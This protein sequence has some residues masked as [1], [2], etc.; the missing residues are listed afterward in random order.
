MKKL[1]ASFLIIVLAVAL[2]SVTAFA[3]K[4][5][6]NYATNLAWKSA[7]SAQTVFE[8]GVATSTNINNKWDSPSVDLLPAAKAALGDNDEITLVIRLE[9]RVTFTSGNEEELV[10][11]RPLFRGT[12][13]FP[14]SDDDAWTE[15]YDEALNGEEPLFFIRTKNVMKYFE[16]GNLELTDSEWFVFETEL[17]LTAAQINCDFITGW[18]FCVDSISD[19]SIIANIQFRNVGVY[20]LDDLPEPTATPTP[21]PTPTPTATVKPTA[22]PTS[23]AQADATVT[24]GAQDAD[25]TSAPDG[26]VTQTVSNTA[27][28]IACVVSGV[29]V[30]GAFGAVLFLKKKKG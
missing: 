1:F 14:T 2:F 24:E 22:R 30:I 19:P 26:Q 3:E 28:I 23:T 11:A 21:V 7:G 10:T 27:T 29:V 16:A 5:P 20:N 9:A 6:T 12:S 25:V 18:N 8:N 17:D 4:E 13:I 15:A